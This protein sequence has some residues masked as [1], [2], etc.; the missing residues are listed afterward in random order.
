M[1]E[2]AEIIVHK[3][4]QPNLVAHLF[5]SDALASEDDAEIRNELSPFSQEGHS[6]GSFG[7][8]AKPRFS[9]DL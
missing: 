4:D 5:D 2:V 6:T 7:F 8:A 3:A 9:I 1:V